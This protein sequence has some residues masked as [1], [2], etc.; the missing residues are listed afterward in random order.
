[1]SKTWG[2]VFLELI[3][4]QPVG[5]AGILVAWAPEDRRFE[6]QNQEVAQELT[7]SVQ[8]TLRG[9]NTDDSALCQVFVEVQ[10]VVF[11]PF[12]IRVQ[13]SPQIAVGDNLCHLG[14]DAR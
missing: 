3:D 1:M 5:A 6:L 11:T 10:L 2:G 4:V 13:D 14:A 9:G 12:H 8:K 7:Q